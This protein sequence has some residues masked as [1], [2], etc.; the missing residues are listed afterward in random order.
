M[1]E[2]LFS[3]LDDFGTD[4]T[5]D[6]LE[7]YLNTPTISTKNLDP[8]AWWHAIGISS[9]LG[10]MAIDFL[11]APASSCDVERGFSRG[12]LT[13]TKLRHALSDESTRASTVL[14]AW[15]EIPGLLPEA[16]IIQAFKDK[17]RRLK[18]KDKRGKT[19]KDTE[20]IVVSVLESEAEDED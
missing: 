3:A 19:N 2:S 12:G 5:S 16:D 18:G 11:S 1:D 6:E 9:P 13:V 14:H 4:T 15:S 20:S 7:E 10:R 8:I 17:S